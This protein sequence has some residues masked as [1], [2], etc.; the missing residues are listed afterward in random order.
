MS[1]TKAIVALLLIL[2]LMSGCLDLFG[3]DSPVQGTYADMGFV[4]DPTGEDSALWP[5][6]PE[7]TKLRV[8]SHSFFG[9]FDDAAAQFTALTGAEVE[10]VEAA[11]AGDL[12]S[13]VLAAGTS[14]DADVV[15]GLDN[16]LVGQAIAGER[17]RGFTPAH[18]DRVPE[19]FRFWPSTPWQA[20]P[21]DHGYIAIN[22]DPTHR[23]GEENL[24]IHNLYDVRTHAD[25]F[26]TDDPRRD[27]PGLGF[28]LITIGFFGENEPFY[29]WQDYWRDLFANNVTI[30]SN[31]GASYVDRF[32]AGYGAP[33]Y[34]GTGLADKALVTS[35]TE[36]PAYE[37]YF[38]PNRGNDTLAVPLIGSNMTWHQIQTT[39]ILNGTPVPAAAEAWIEFTLTDYYQA[40]SASYNGVYPIVADM[41][42][43]DVY[44]GKDPTPGSFVPTFV[45]PAYIGIKLPIWLDAWAE[46]CRESG[47]CE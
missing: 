29:D 21:T 43:D 11:G 8:M 20:T 42:V 45:D 34:G 25:L 19:E 18:A 23:I 9:S 1:P 27:S 31:W 37:S 35:Y 24:N 33:D 28:L 26:V 32:S 38:A 47:K 22:W 5:Q 36:S 46:I 44:A 41:S 13:Q 16:A 3:R 40:M 12:L 14:P 17:L 4:G 2:P 7:G 30:A 15:Y 6:F 10:L 39:A